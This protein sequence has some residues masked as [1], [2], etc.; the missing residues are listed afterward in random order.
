MTKQDKSKVNCQDVSQSGQGRDK[1][2]RT[3]QLLWSVLELVSFVQG[4]I[5]V[6]CSR[7]ERGVKEE[8]LDCYCVNCGVFIHTVLSTY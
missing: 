5:E 8:K 4:P 2:C 6:S 3:Y 1:L 7:Q